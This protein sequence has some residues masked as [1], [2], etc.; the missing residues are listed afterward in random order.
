M[1]PH[2]NDQ[3]AATTTEPATLLVS[4]ELSQ[5]QWVLTMQQP[6]NSKL[7]RFAIPAYDKE[8]GT[9]HSDGAAPACGATLR[10]PGDDRQHLRGRT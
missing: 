9:E 4:F 1:G 6:H 8:K 7:S 10:P 5:K 3:P 2:S